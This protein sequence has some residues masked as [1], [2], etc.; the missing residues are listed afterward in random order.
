MFNAR[1]LVLKYSFIN[2]PDAIVVH[3][4]RVLYQLQTLYTFLIMIRNKKQHI[5]KGC[6]IILDNR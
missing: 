4:V 1:F 5:E 3:V 6:C 2:V